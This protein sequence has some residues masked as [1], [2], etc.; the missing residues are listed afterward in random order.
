MS[1]RILCA[2]TSAKTR[3]LYLIF[4]FEPMTA[5]QF[6][7]MLGAGLAAAGGQFSITKAYYYATAREISVYDYSQII[8]SAVL[9]FVLFG[10]M[11]DRYSIIGYIIICAMA[12][13][14]FLYNRKEDMK[15]V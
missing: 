15:N 9:E 13:M 10:Q 14:M 1:G 12:V 6:L 2:D 8:F 5:E 4:S 7:I 11:P 3:I